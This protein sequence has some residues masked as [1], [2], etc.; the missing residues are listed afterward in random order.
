MHYL[1]GEKNDQMTADD[2]S[3]N[4]EVKGGQKVHF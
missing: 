1:Q 4:M 2:S 3:D